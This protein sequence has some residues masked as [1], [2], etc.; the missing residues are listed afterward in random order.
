MESGAIAFGSDWPGLFLRG[1]D[2]LHYGH[3]LR[4]L[5]AAMERVVAADP[6]AVAPEVYPAVMVLPNL[7][8]K[9]LSVDVEDPLQPHLQLRSARECLASTPTMRGPGPEESPDAKTEVR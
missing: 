7:V 4:M 5:L 6:D 2:A 1:D 3:H 8:K 9:L